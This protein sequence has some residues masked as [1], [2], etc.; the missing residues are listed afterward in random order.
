MP[1]PQTWIDRLLDDWGSWKRGENKTGLGF[2][3][4]VSWLNERVQGQRSSDDSRGTVD[5]DI[6]RVDGLMEAKPPLMPKE[7]IHILCVHHIAPG[8]DKVK[9][10]EIG[11]HKVRYYERLKSAQTCVEALL[12]AQKNRHAA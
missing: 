9:Y 11:L 4:A 8:A 3:S 6:L 7:W 1:K 10:L 2:P 12:L 5:L